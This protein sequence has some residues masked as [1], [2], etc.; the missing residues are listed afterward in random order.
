[1]RTM[2][3][4]W[5]DCANYVISRNEWEYQRRIT[6]A[7]VVYSD[8][9]ILSVEQSRGVIDGTLSIGNTVSSEL[10]ASFIPNDVPQEIN[11]EDEVTL[12][13]RIKTLYD[14]ATEWFPFGTFYIDEAVMDGVYLKISC[15]DKLA[16]LNKP[17]KG[18]SSISSSE[19]LDIIL[20]EAGLKLDNRSVLGNYQLKNANRLTSR[21]VLGYIGSLNAGNWYVTEENKLRHIVPGV[22]PNSI[23]TI[24]KDNT[25]KLAT[26]PI[27]SFGKITVKAS[28]DQAI[29]YSAGSGPGEF[30][31]Y[32]PWG[33]QDMADRILSVMNGYK[34][35]PGD[36]G[37][38]EINP[39][40][41]IGDTITVDGNKVQLSL[42]NY[43]ARMF[44]SL[45]SPTKTDKFHQNMDV[46]NDVE[47]EPEPS[48]DESCKTIELGDFKQN[49]SNSDKSLYFP[50]DIQTADKFK[51]SD[52]YC[53]NLNENSFGD[54]KNIR[55][56]L[57]A[58]VDY[59]SKQKLIMKKP[60]NLKFT[61]SGFINLDISNFNTSKIEDMS[62]MFT[63]V[64]GRNINM[65]HF[66]TDSCKNMNNM[67]SSS[68]FEGIL[69]LS[70][71]NTFNITDMSGMFWQA[72]IKSLDISSFNTSN[73]VNMKN[74]FIG[75]K[76]DNFNDSFKFFD[77]SNVES[78]EGMFQDVTTEY[79]D[80]SN[81][82]F[83]WNVNSDKY[84]SLGA[85]FAGSNIKRLVM[86]KT[87]LSI[88]FPNDYGSIYDPIGSMFKGSNVENIDM[89]DMFIE[90]STPSNWD[91]I[92]CG[93]EM[94]RGSKAKSIKMFDYRPSR[95]TKVENIG[96][97][98]NKYYHINS[99]EGVNMFRDC[100]NLESI[101]TIEPLILSNGMFVNTPN[102]T[103][104]VDCSGRISKDIDYNLANVFEL[105]SSP[106]LNSGIQT[107]IVADQRTKLFLEEAGYNSR[108]DGTFVEVVAKLN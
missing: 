96:E 73:V 89:S 48:E 98:T 86:P 101:E 43:N 20:S 99:I 44:L 15:F 32:N 93:N 100:V 11:L 45:V 63:S 78:F 16:F 13:V 75:S 64:N 23:L 56:D 106:F 40:I 42:V 55:L 91:K 67:F 28:T 62:G 58:G 102:L 79:L 72:E 12:E 60:L 10:I 77:T 51:N 82:K 49:I 85:M 108:G 38:T 90:F 87:T 81:F 104:T 17:F 6:I 2:S 7:G 26:K 33:N 19:A 52:G 46:V 66:R 3:K 80:I 22:N 74:M 21:Q 83:N 31:V 54:F 105:T 1:M 107:V 103:G 94:F 30:E 34:I 59:G 53:Y 18:G 76:I 88:N 5:H 57:L 68:K 8:D 39:A 9:Q 70:N 36:V 41:E 84:A 27:M 95:Y 14:G 65:E 29:S 97:H 37:S 24:G 61:I 69:R 35:Y 25:K 71:F 4:L 92:R 50:R 47:K